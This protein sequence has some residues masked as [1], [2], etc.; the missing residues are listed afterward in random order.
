LNRPVKRATRLARVPR[1]VAA[2]S[3]ALSGAIG[4]FLAIQ[5]YGSRLHAPAPDLR[6]VATRLQ[7]PAVDPLASVLVALAAVVLIGRC[8]GRWLQTLGQAPV[9][10]E[11]LAGIVLGPSVLGKLSPAASALLLPPAAAPFLTVVGQL[12]IILFMFRMGLHVNG[13]IL[14]PQAHAAIA[15]SHTSIVIPFLLGSGLALLLYPRFSSSDVSFA[16]FALFVGV[17]MSI[18]AFPVLARILTERGLVGTPLGTLAITCAAVDDLT[19]WCLLSFVIAV[20]QGTIVDAVP[21]LTMSIGFLALMVLAIRP[22]LGRMLSRV[23]RSGRRDELLPFVIAG[24]LLSA[25]TTQAIGVHA[26]F[27]AFLFGAILPHSSLGGRPIAQKLESAESDLLLPAYFAVTGM[28]T[29][30]A[31]LSGV[32]DWLACAAIVLTATIG[33]LGGTFVGARL[34]GLD[35]RTALSLGVLMNTRGLMEL[36]VLNIGLDLGVL[37]PRLFAMF[38]IMALVTTVA[39]TPALHV[40]NATASSGRRA[41]PSA[42]HSLV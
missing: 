1:F 10:G 41:D 6:L 12:G 11:V 5:V 2:Y 22:A 23:A 36:I 19:A 3:A 33:K 34:T 20:A 16:S 7:G 29:E 35:R 14:R 15:T 28:R 26:V 25:L 27:G 37:S 4:L 30:I 9:I 13:D 21:V 32:H 18:T 17:A 24:A 38:V 31:L 39:T 40:L 8:L 42:A